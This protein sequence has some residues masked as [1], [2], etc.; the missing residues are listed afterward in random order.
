MSVLVGNGHALPSDLYLG[1]HFAD[2][3]VF[4]LCATSLAA[5]DIETQVVNGVAIEPILEYSTG[6]I[7]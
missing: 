1:I 6:T 2:A 5:L 3:S 4:I 7:R